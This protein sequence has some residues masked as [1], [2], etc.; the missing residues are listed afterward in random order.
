MRTVSLAAIGAC[1]FASAACTAV[2][3]ISDPID[4]GALPAADVGSS[5]GDALVSPDTD[6]GNDSA[7][8]DGATVEAPTDTTQ[9]E[10][11]VDCATLDDGTPCATTPRAIC[12]KGLCE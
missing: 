2:L 6:G 10:S 4:E 5:D 1:V 9:V 7:S 11:S 12:L 3:G 8:P